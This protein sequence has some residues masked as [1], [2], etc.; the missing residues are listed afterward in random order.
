[1]C[2]FPEVLKNRMDLGHWHL[3]HVSTYCWWFG[4]LV[5][6]GNRGENSF[7]SRTLEGH[8]ISRTSVERD[9]WIVDVVLC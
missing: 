9:T 5:V 1:V 6:W 2:N 4:S 7:E 3:G 8:S